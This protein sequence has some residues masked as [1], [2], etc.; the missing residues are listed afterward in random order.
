MKITL[1]KSQAY[2]IITACEWAQN[3]DFSDSDPINKMWQRIIDKLQKA[4]EEDEAK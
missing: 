2:N 3:D 4:I 1:T